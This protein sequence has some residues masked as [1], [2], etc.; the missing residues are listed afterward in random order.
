MWKKSECFPNAL[1]ASYPVHIRSCMLMYWQLLKTLN[2]V[3]SV[4]EHSNSLKRV[5]LSSAH[6]LMSSNTMFSNLFEDEPLKTFVVF[7]LA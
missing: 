3:A 7:W 2:H 4:H 5:N 6:M 1:D